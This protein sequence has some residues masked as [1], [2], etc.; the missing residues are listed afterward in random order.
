MLIYNYLLMSNFKVELLL[1]VDLVVFDCFELYSWLQENLIEDNV[2]SF[3]SLEEWMSR[4]VNF[5][6]F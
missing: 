1:V 3:Y 6:F 5:D 2:T 4:L